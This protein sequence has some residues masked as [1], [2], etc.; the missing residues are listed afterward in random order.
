M[1]R[2]S[3]PVRVINA[4]KK[5]HRTKAEIAV[6]EAGEAALLTGEKIRER[7]QTKENG[8]AHREFLRVKKLLESIGKNDAIYEPVI[9]RYCLLQAECT[10]LE[11]KMTD[12]EECAKALRQIVEKWAAEGGLD[13]NAVCRM[14]RYINKI[15]STV[16]TCD[17]HLQQKRSMLLAIEK[18]C[19]MTIAAALRTVPKKEA[20]QAEDPLLKLL[21]RSG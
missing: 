7:Q 15:Y 20:H 11:E 4:E 1:A 9:N 18:E 21:K 14:M 2:P 12:M 13:E 19:A 10:G 8:I 17:A 16:N 6:R 5:S 3:K